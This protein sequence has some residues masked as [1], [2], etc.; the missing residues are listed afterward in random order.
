MALGS[1]GCSHTYYRNGPVTLNRWSFGDDVAVRQINDSANRQG[2]H[3]VKIGALDS[4]KSEALKK[5]VGA[6]IDAVMTAAP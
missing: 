2:D 4:N 6:A 1:L 3:T 5:A